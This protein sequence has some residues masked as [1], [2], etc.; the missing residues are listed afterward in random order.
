MRS[1]RYPPSRSRTPLLVQPQPR[2]SLLLFIHA[3][4]LSRLMVT[5]PPIVRLR[6][7]TSPG[8][9]IGLGTLDCGILVWLPVNAISALNLSSIPAR[10]SVWGS[11]H[12]HLG[13]SA[14]PRGPS[15]GAPVMMTSASDQ[16]KP[17]PG[18]PTSRHRTPWRMNSYSTAWG[19]SSCR[20]IRLPILGDRSPKH[21][22]RR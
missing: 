14:R 16:Y 9:G 3:S 10:M 6:S 12:H 15:L 2:H 4:S 22:S 5:L 1:W 19:C 20:S 8:R 21:R 18:L 13:S 11:N 7:C 17:P